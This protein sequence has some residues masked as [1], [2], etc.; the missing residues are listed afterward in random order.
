[1]KKIKITGLALLCALVF[2]G[3][4]KTEE[5]APASKG[6]TVRVSVTAEDLSVKVTSNSS[7]RFTWNKDDAIGIWTGTKVTKFTLDPE[8]DGYGY[9]EFVGE[10]ADGESVSETSYAVYPYSE[11]ATATATSYTY[12]DVSKWEIPAKNCMLYAQGGKIEDNGNVTFTFHHATAYFR[13]NVKNIRPA[14]NGLYIESAG[15]CFALGAT[16]DFSGETPAITASMDESVI[17]P[18][19]A[20][21][22]VADVTL[23]IPIAAGTYTQQWGQGGLKF[24]I[25]CYSDANWWSTKFDDFAGYFGAGTGFTA[26]AGEYYVFP[27]IT[28]ANA[29]SQDDSGTGV[30]DGIEDSSV[31][32]QPVDDFWKV[33]L[34]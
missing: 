22:N 18:V 27:D 16:V 10:V 20:H 25:A 28:C 19:P 15:Q 14:C 30:N 26:T 11:G 8:W 5:S 12:P 1:M 6:R 29:K 23:V 32:T 7:G 21:E 4:A 2:A 34:N 33:Q 31:N 24:R 13:V 17:Y 9:G 3:C